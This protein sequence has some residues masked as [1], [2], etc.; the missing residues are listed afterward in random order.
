MIQIRSANLSMGWFG[1]LY[2]QSDRILKL[3]VLTRPHWNWPSIWYLQR[4]K[5]IWLKENKG[6]VVVNA[7]CTSTLFHHYADN[8]CLS[9]HRDPRSTQNARCK[10]FPVYWFQFRHGYSYCLSLAYKATLLTFKKKTDK[11]QTASKENSV[12]KHDGE[13]YLMLIHGGSACFSV[14]KAD[15]TTTCNNKIMHKT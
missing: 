3:H 4:C 1:I 12:L 9:R 7:S 8:I 15:S 2:R 10:H 6:E 13:F 14:V 5:Q 11:N